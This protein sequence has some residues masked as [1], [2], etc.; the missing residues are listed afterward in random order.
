MVNALQQVF[1]YPFMVNAFRAGAIVAV[2]A[3]AMGWFMVLRRETF[4]GHTLSVVGFPGAAAAVLLGWP[5]AFG[6]F[7]FCIAAALVIGAASSAASGSASTAYR[8]ESALIGT[9]QAMALASGFLFVSLYQGNLNGL[10]NLLFGNFLGIT[11]GQV[12]VLLVL[13]V[14]ALFV[15]AV[16]GRRLLF[17]S[18][19]PEV[20]AAAGVRVSALS[21]GFLVLLGVAVAEASQ[22]TGS[23]LVF[24]LLV[25]PPATAQVITG[26]PVAGMILSV[27][28]GVAV[29]W[30]GL[31]IA[32]YTPYPVGAFITTLSF[33]AYVVA[34]VFRWAATRQ[35]ATRAVALPEVA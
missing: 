3:G 20:A 19:D 29:T 22:I 28:L 15:L 32:Y 18:V 23:L 12:L 34:R 27:A 5:S 26:R 10:T 17:A 24:A 14:A 30:G 25:L 31:L 1:A 7:G 35:R 11:S 6:Y 16:I 9:V 13:S 8:E 33:V 4:A 21:I 2:V